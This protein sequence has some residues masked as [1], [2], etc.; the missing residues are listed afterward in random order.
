[1]SWNNITPWWMLAL[2]EYDALIAE[3]KH[4][5]AAAFAEK[6]NIPKRVQE[7]TAERRGKK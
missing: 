1:M 5:E 6:N 3:G 4:E 7:V 2:P